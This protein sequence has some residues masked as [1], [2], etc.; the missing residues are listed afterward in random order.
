MQGKE[1]GEIN[2]LAIRY[3]Q[4]IDSKSLSKNFRL[5]FGGQSYANYTKVNK[6]FANLFIFCLAH[7][8]VI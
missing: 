8:N 3:H 7:K 1:N 4:K 5:L 2:K 6:D